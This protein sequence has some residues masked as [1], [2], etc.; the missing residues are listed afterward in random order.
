MMRGINYLAGL[1]TVF[2]FIGFYCFKAAFQKSSSPHGSSPKRSNKV[3]LIT[4]A[5]LSISL[6]IYLILKAVRDI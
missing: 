5:I 2:L 3:I 6:G 1:G 4:G